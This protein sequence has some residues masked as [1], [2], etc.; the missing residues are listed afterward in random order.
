M[1]NGEA[2]H[3]EARCAM[4]KGARGNKV[5][6]VRQREP[7]N[8]TPTS[9]G[10]H[11]L[12]GWRACRSTV[13]RLTLWM[14]YRYR[15][16][17]TLEAKTRPRALSQHRKQSG[18]GVQGGRLACTC[19]LVGLCDCG[20]LDAGG[21]PMQARKGARRRLSRQRA[22]MRVGAHEP[23][24]VVRV[25]SVWGKQRAWC[26]SSASNGENQTE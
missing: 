15:P 14:A 24:T 11:F 3:W 1:W 12:L 25:R 23:R 10:C 16:L 19:L 20:V 9:V 8:V 13:V 22:R 7:A 6:R 2:S 18:C 5:I 17:Q 4:V 21:G 26:A